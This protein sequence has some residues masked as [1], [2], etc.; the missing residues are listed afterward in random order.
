MSLMRNI[1]GNIA[2]VGDFGLHTPV[3]FVLKQK[4]MVVEESKSQRVSQTAS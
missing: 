1:L 2:E 3:P 4:R